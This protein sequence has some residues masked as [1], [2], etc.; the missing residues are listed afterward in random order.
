M[1]EVE[2]F[3]GAIEAVEHL[4]RSPHRIRVLNTLYRGSRTRDEL[5]ELT[6][7]SRFTLSRTLGEFEDRNW[8]VRSG[9]HYELT[10][11]GALIS[12][13]LG[14]LL[15]NLD[16]A[17]KLDGNL[18]WLPIQAFD[19]DLGRLRDATVYTPSRTDH[20]A[21]IRLVAE[22]VRAA[23]QVRG[24]VTGVSYEIMEAGW[25][26]T[27]NGDLAVAGILDEPTVAAIQADE[28]LADMLHEMITTADARLY[29][30]DGAGPLVMHVVCEEIVYMCG[31]DEDGP[32]PGT[33]ETDDPGV[34]SWAESYFERIRAESTP[35]AAESLV[36]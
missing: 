28:E 21:H 35:L 15:S 1:D 25:D 31:H 30:F 6:D 29:R 24:T 20:T 4:A 18:E 11:H 16:V 27:V 23:E 5:K 12:S 8:I 32:A 14:S 2:D 9:Q 3:E 34:S 19:F 13:E 7:V 33:V 10:G 36:S 26:S 17:A 22:A